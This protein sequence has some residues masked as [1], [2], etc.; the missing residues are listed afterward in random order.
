MRA[1]GGQLGAEN[2]DFLVVFEA[3]GRLRERQ[4][5]SSAP[6][7]LIFYCFFKLLARWGGAAGGLGRAAGRRPARRRKY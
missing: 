1:A 6:K 7:I 3:L 4:E 2:I 5:A